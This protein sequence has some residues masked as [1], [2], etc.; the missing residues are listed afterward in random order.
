MMPNTVTAHL[1]G[2]E[3]VESSDAFEGATWSFDFF[4]DVKN[5]SI[6]RESWRSG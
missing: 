6:K 2:S 1:I 5:A 3:C 4:C